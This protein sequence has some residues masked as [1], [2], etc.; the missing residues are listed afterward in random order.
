MA[1][2]FTLLDETDSVS[3]VDGIHPIA[4]FR[5]PESHESLSLALA[6]VIEEVGGL[7]SGIEVQ[8]VHYNVSAFALNFTMLRI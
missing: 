6:D 1:F 3:S 7:G 8:G 5:E 2:A 4:I